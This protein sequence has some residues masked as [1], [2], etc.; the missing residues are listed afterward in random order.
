MCSAT[1]GR[2]VQVAIVAAEANSTG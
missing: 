2:H 1:H